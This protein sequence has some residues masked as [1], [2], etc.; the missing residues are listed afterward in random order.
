MSDTPR[1][2]VIVRNAERHQ[3]SFLDAY[4]NIRELAKELERENNQLRSANSTKR[5]NRKASSI[6]KAQERLKNQLVHP[7]DLLT[8]LKDSVSL[9]CFA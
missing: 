6:Q 2:D 9:C 7:T 1:T 8:N 4:L 3:E 5:S